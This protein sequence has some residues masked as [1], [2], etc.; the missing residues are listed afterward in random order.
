MA[1]FN[2]LM[3]LLQVCYNLFVHIRL[4]LRVF[5][6]SLAPNLSALRRIRRG[7]KRAASYSSTDDK[8]R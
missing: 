7:E 1:L 4:Q 8:G 2:F 6:N 3:L 5:H